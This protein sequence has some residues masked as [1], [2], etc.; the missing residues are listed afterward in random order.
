MTEQEKAEK[1][2]PACVSQEE[3]ERR[4]NKGSLL[5]T[6]GRSRR[7]SLSKEHIRLV[8]LGNRLAAMPQMVY[9]QDVNEAVA[10]LYGKE[11]QIV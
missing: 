6:R 8:Y 5:E 2:F 3:L 4:K 11:Y 7:Y 10:A 9:S 1:T